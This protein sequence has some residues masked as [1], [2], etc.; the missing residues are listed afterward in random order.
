MTVKDLETLFDYGHWA[1]KKLIEVISRL[2]PEQ[3]AQTADG[4][5]GSVRN[6]M[7]HV[8]SA[9][10]GW[11]SPSL[12]PD[13][14]PPLNPADYPTVE[15]LVA[16]WDKVATY[17]RDFLSGLRDEDLAR[18]V[19]FALGGEEKRRMPMGELLQHAAHHGVHHR[20]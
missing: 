14:G 5:H 10:W 18:D 9:E 13:R 8:L 16:A 2:T 19:E 4:S 12:R 17:L 3:Y 6:T 1:N 7:V 15:S 11:L 20:G